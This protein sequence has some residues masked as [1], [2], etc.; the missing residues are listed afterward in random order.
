MQALMHSWR[1]A[2]YVNNSTLAQGQYGFPPQFGFVPACMQAGDAGCL[3]Q[4]AA[5][6]FGLG[7]DDFAN[8]ALVYQGRRTRAGRGVGKQNMHVA[9]AHFAAVDTVCRSLLAFD[10]ARYV[11]RIM[12]VELG[13]R[14]AVAVVDRHY[15]FGIVAGRTRVGARKDHVVH[16]DGTQRFVRRFAH[17]PAQGFDEVRLPAAIRTN[18][19]GEAGLD[20]KVSRLDKRLEAKQA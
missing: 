2:N 10:T 5:A 18:H 19:A 12:L 4:N 14:L 16:V 11:K 17:H 7:L 20:Q 8:P 1:V 13:R 15:D 9:R 3:F 6:L